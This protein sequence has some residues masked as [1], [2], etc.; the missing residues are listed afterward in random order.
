MDFVR[1]IKF[2]FNDENWITKVVVG[3][4]L[5]L[6]PFFG[7]GYMIGVARNVMRNRAHPLPGTDEVGQVILD[8]IMASIA[9]IV[10]AIPGLLAGCVIGI[11]GSILGDSDVG[12]VIVACMSLFV[13]LASL[14]YAIPAAAM[15]WIGAMRYA[16]SGNFSDFVQFGSLL[17]E[18]RSHVSSLV[19]L[20]L[21]VLGVVLIASLVAPL[22]VITCIGIPLLGFWVQ[23]AQGHLLGQAALEMEQAG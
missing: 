17:R 21:Y 11:F 3:T 20:L 1:A 6:I 7:V 12:G 10:Y 18:A 2:P 22:F 23:I 15:Y 13:V 9:A 4:L 14:I 19:I 8:G 5:N 16:E